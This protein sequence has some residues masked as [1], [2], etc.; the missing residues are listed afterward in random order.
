MIITEVIMAFL[1]VVSFSVL[2][3]AP[4]S[5]Y[6]F[7]GLTGGIGRAAFIAFNGL[8][9][10]GIYATLIASMIITFFSR[11]FA[12]K[13]RVPGIIYLRGGVFPLVPGASIYYT[14]YY[15][16]SNETGLAAVSG[17]DAMSRA[18]ALAFGIMISSQ[19]PAKFFS[20]G[21]GSGGGNDDIKM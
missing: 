6:L 1:G 5:E 19:I 3:G 2:L 17:I 13:R 21:K 8:F 10:N 9:S 15:I 7:A 12:A 11:L 20:L 18:L 14:A 16:F 4:K